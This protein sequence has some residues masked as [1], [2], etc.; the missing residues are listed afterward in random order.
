MLAAPFGLRVMD[1]R[2]K[3]FNQQ[4]LL[5]KAKK[6]V[7]DPYIIVDLDNGPVIKDDFKF[8]I[9]KIGINTT[10][11]IESNNIDFP[12]KVILDNSPLDLNKGKFYEDC[13]K[14]FR[15]AEHLYFDIRYKGKR[16]LFCVIGKAVNHSDGL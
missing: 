8:S 2:D 9:I 5:P 13:E 4:I 1:F 14:Q 12:Y 11:E 7:F 16:N 10:C 15:H 6:W 3:Y